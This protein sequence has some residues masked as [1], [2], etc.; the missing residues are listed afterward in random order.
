MALISLSQPHA[1]PCWGLQSMS[2]ALPAPTQNPTACPAAAVLAPAWLHLALGS[3][4]HLN[5]L[6][7]LSQKCTN[8]GDCPAVAAPACAWLCL[9]LAGA[10]QPP[11][12]HAQA[13]AGPWTQGVVPLPA[14]AGCLAALP[15]ALPAQRRTDRRR[16]AAIQGLA[17]LG[18]AV[19]V[20]S[21][22]GSS[23]SASP[24]HQANHMPAS[25]PTNPC[26]KKTL[27][28]QCISSFLAPPHMPLHGLPCSLQ[29]LW[30]G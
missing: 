20:L 5:A 22:V 19:S 28:L 25:S 14:L 18:Y 8:T 11:Q 2:L 24:A 15:G 17:A 6:S 21:G 16:Q 12:L 29:R 4:V 23:A 1:T 26:A 10:D 27:S 7:H 13:A 9:C 3:V 30:C